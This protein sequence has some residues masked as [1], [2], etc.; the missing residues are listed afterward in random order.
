MNTN[1]KVIV[2]QDILA[3]KNGLIPVGT[4]GQ[5][6]KVDKHYVIVYF[7]SIDQDITVMY[8]GYIEVTK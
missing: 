6:K 7:P 2:T 8:D 1:D 5:A 3:G 4:V